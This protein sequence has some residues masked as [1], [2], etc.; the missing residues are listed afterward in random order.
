MPKH[1]RLGK[2]VWPETV[3]LFKSKK[4]NSIRTAI[5]PPARISVLADSFTIVQ[6]TCSSSSP[7]SSSKKTSW[8][9]EVPS[10]QPGCGPFLRRPTI[11][12]CVY[13]A[14]PWGRKPQTPGTR[15]VGWQG[16][17]G[18]GA[19]SARFRGEAAGTFRVA[20]KWIGIGLLRNRH[21]S[22]RV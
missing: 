1:H 7:A 10:E 3:I 4:M 12:Q 14:E 21:P 19:P 15:E 16:Y 8:S 13:A 6:S 5:P 22:V 11:P 2:N 20:T 18:V 9:G 17:G